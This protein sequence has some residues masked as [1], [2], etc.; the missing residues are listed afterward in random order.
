MKCRFIHHPDRLTHPII[1]SGVG[2]STVGWYEAT[3]FV[4]E[5]LSRYKPGEVGVVAG[6]RTTNEDNYVLQKFTRAVLHTNTIDCC[7]RI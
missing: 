5:K 3:R 6:V 1:R 7:A 2:R 4:A